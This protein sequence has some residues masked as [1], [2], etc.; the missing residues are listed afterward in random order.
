MVLKD[1]A[2]L[3]ENVKA[4]GITKKIVV[5][6]AD[7]AHTLEAVMSAQKD[8]I[9]SPVFIGDAAAIKSTLDG[10]G[11]SQDVYEVYDESDF[12]KA[13]ELGVKLI[14][15]GKG[16]FLMKGKLET[17]QILRAV[18]KPDADLS[19]PNG[20]MSHVAVNWIP[21]YHKLL[22]TT[23]G[24]MNVAPNFDMKLAELVNAVNTL[25]A[26]GYEEPK[27]AVLANAEKVD[28]KIKESVEAG[29]LKEM[30]VNGE[31]KNCIVEGPVALDI[32]VVK[33]RAE[34]KHFESPVAGDADIILSPNIFTS[35]TLGKS[36]V[37]LAGGKMA[38]LIVGAKVP[39]ILTSRGSSSEEKYN[40]I[41][42]AAAV[43]AGSEN[44]TN[45]QVADLAGRKFW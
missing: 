36:L 45:E 14:G 33:E 5:V 4:S 21:S 32:A 37:E 18:L 23:D 25:R 40:S 2:H 38:G 20:A 26:L 34:V 35:N 17:S 30:Y 7:D 24:G 13:A 9:V 42:L 11:V 31:I 1:F 41:V 29:Q 27:V 39:I 16:D 10:L 43:A 3:I 6:A 44:I 12:D 8:G 22:L 19:R 15:E 28:P